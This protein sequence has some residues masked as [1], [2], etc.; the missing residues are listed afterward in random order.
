MCRVWGLDKG[1]TL[2]LL[3]APPTTVPATVQPM[4][5][6][7]HPFIWIVTGVLT[8]FVIMGIIIACIH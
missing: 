2:T 5:P 1:F 3:A 8:S 6:A 4:A 7:N